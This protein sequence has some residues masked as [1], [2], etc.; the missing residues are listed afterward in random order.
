MRETLAAGLLALAGQDPTRPLW[1]PMCGSGTLVIEGALAARRIAPGRGRRFAAEDWPLAA[2][3]DWTAR[4]QRLAAVALA[5]AP[6]PVVGTDLNAGSLGTA[7]RNARR[8][9]VL[10]DLRLERLDVAAATPGAM[11]PGLLVSNLPYGIRVGE[12][13]SLA[14][15]DA[16]LARVLG[17]PFAAWRV[18][19]LVDDAKRLE[20]MGRGTP[21]AVHA[22]R[23]GGIPVVLGVWG[24]QPSAFRG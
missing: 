23:N 4:R 11:G 7:R 20:R 19:L 22:L 12:R 17:G 13:G 1:D 6:S 16:G 10:E 2:S 21:A 18:A 8:A 3:V 9:G 14:A 5:R 24:A 15:L